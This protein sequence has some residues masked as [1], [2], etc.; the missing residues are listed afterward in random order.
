MMKF[1]YDAI[2]VRHIFEKGHCFLLLLNKDH[3]GQYTEATLCD[4]FYNAVNVYYL[5]AYARLNSNP[6]EKLEWAI[7][8]DIRAWIGGYKDTFGTMLDYSQA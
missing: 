7:Q 4:P 8:R 6:V 3:K 1:K 2:P 5:D